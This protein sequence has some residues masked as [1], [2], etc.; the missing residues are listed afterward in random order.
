MASITFQGNPVQTVGELPEVSAQA[1][2]FELV[3]ADLA[4][5]SSEE[6][7]GRRVILSIFPSLDTGVC[8]KALREFNERATAL[9]NTTV[10]CASKDLPFAAERFCSAEGIENVSTGSAFRS[11]LGEDYGVTMTDGPLEGLLSRAVV[12]I[13]EQGKVV[14]TQQVSEVTD[15]PDYDAALAAL[16]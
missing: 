9:E 3:G 4:P 13:D 15:E 11:S 5:V 2:S 7:A 1:P 10:V 8:A 16:A 14:Y 6:L 12:V